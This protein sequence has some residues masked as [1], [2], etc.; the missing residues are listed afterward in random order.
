MVVEGDSSARVL[1]LLA[2]L[3]THLFAAQLDP[4]VGCRVSFGGNP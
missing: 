1:E 2:S 3:L 4:L